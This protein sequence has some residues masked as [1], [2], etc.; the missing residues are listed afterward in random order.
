[1]NP[2]IADPERVVLAGDWHGDRLHAASVIQ[3]AAREG[4]AGIVQLGDFGVWPGHGGK[5]FLDAVALSLDLSGIWLVFVDGNHEDFTQLADL[6]PDD[7]GAHPLRPNLWR[8]PRG[9]RWTWFDRTW[10]ALGGAT[11][12]D[13]PSRRPYVDW[14][15]EE[16]LT[17]GDYRAA[18]SGG[19]VDV[20][21]SHDAPAGYDVPGIPP[22]SVW[23]PAELARADRHRGVMRAVCDEVKPS[24]LF[25]GHFHSRY[26]H[27]LDLGGAPMLIE[28]LD[29][30]QAPWRDAS[31]I[32]DVK[33]MELA[34]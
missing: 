18:T 5:S 11:S 22:A 24:W 8:L 14:W 4:C 13:R 34:G 17:L 20:M 32:L 25:H 3:W 27:L 6:K 19:L 26:S 23:P 31:V 7:T 9:F 33:T 28:G 15:P 30:S 16:E 1:M 10:M 21:V 12:L 2:F 29:E